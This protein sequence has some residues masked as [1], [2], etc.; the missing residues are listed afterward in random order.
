AV[1]AARLLN[2][3]VPIEQFPA[4]VLRDKIE[5]AL[6]FKRLA[7]LRTD[8]PLFESVDV[9]EWRGPTDAFAATVER[10]GDTRLMARTQRARSAR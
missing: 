7:T 6:L 9:L 10:L 1:S 4:D 5:L 3:H 2:K 8:A